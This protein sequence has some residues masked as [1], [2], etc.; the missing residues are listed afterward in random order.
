[1]AN[2]YWGIQKGPRPNAD[3]TGIGNGQDG[4]EREREKSTTGARY[5]NGHGPTG[6]LL[7]RAVPGG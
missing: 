1:M 4:K 6:C 2:Y 5:I 7:I 3:W